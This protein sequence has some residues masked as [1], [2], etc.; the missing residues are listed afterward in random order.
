MSQEGRVNLLHCPRAKKKQPIIHFAP[1]KTD[2]PFIKL[3]G[4]RQSL[5]SYEMNCVTWSHQYFSSMYGTHATFLMVSFLLYSVT[6]PNSNLQIRYRVVYCL[7]LK[8][9]PVMSVAYAV[10]MSCGSRMRSHSKF[11]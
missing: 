10:R 1:I 6:I 2:R 7:I 8:L 9:E 11:K 3:S 4:L 5:D